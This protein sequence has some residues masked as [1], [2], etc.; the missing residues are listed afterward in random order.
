MSQDVKNCFQTSPQR[1]NLD[2]ATYHK[3]VIVYIY[4]TKIWIIY[5]L[6][7]LWVIDTLQKNNY[8]TVQITTEKL[9]LLQNLDN[10]LTQNKPLNWHAHDISILSFASHL[11]LTATQSLPPFQK[12][13]C[14]LS[15]RSGIGCR[16]FSE[17]AESRHLKVR[18]CHQV[19]LLKDTLSIT[20][21]PKAIKAVS[22]RA[23]GK[24]WLS[25]VLTAKCL[26][27]LGKWAL[28]WMVHGRWQ[29]KERLRVLIKR[30]EVEH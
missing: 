23:L 12:T 19:C 7:C 4:H 17:I 27:M 3:P 22:V 21:E 11:S 10:Q 2:Q 18:C 6:R 9:Q 5:T 20:S 14:Q 29:G 1:T 16:F 13:K 26:K 8:T 24:F 25:E 15:D 30:V 28:G